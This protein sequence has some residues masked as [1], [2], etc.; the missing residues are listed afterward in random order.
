MVRNETLVRNGTVAQWQSRTVDGFAGIPASIGRM[1]GTS[2]TGIA[3][4]IYM[5][6][7]PESSQRQ[8]IVDRIEALR[9]HARRSDLSEA[10]RE[11]IREMLSFWQQRLAQI[12][13]TAA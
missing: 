1:N 4:G 9:E 11:D 7:R 8:V 5:R 2:G 6:P 13:R 10:E 3:L 12:D